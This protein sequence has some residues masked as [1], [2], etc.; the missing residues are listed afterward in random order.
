MF[1]CFWKQVR[2][3]KMC[4]LSRSQEPGARHRESMEEKYQWLQSVFQSPEPFDLWL[5]EC[6]RTRSFLWAYKHDNQ[7]NKWWTPIIIL[8]R[9][10]LQY[11]YFKKIIRLLK[12][13]YL[14]IGKAELQ[15][16]GGGRQKEIVCLLIQSPNGCNSY[17][18]RETQTHRTIYN[19]QDN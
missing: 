3:S 8:I 11:Q 9:T 10:W 14:Y 5:L 17:T 1:A 6:A 16:E 2:W 19:Y 4:R 7:K 13:G 15:R 18:Q 12:I